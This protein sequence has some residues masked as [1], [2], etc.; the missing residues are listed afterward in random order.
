MFK[1]LFP[2]RVAPRNLSRIPASTAS[3]ILRQANCR[4]EALRWDIGL[5]RIKSTFGELLPFGVGSRYVK[6]SLSQ[7]IPWW[8]EQ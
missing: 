3:R 6:M 4:N 5:S 1:V 2:H 8:I 7:L